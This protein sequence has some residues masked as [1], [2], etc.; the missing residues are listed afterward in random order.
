MR[1]AKGVTDIYIA[2]RSQLL[3]KRRL[4]RSLSTVL[5]CAVQDRL[6][7]KHLMVCAA[8][9]QQVQD[10]VQSTMQRMVM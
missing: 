10:T 9:T 5:C 1:H 7:S 2:Q 4:T 8:C 6:R 3:S